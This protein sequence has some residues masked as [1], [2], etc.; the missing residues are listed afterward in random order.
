MKKI[1]VISFFLLIGLVILSCAFEN[2][3]KNKTNKSQVDVPPI[4]VDSLLPMVDPKT[5]G[6][7]D[8]K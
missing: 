7:S 3:T 2:T 8:S 6:I 4:N 1:T 5:L